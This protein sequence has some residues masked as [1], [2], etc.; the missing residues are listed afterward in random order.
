[1]LVE[2]KKNTVKTTKINQVSNI[3]L[4][5]SL[6]FFKIFGQKYIKNTPTKHCKVIDRRKMGVAIQG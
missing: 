5:N 4:I 1:M 3:L 6:Y 2:T